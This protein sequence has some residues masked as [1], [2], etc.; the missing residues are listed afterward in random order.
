MSKQ[1]S[2]VI[3]T[4]NNDKIIRKCLDSVKDFNEIVICDMYST[5][6]TIEIAKEYGCKI[7]M[8]ENI[9][10]ADPARNFAISQASNDWVLVVD[11]DEQITPELREY[12]YKFIEDPKDYTALWIPRL[13]YCWGKPMELLY[14]DMIFRLFKK[15]KAYFPPKV[16]GRPQINEGKEFYMPINNRKL[17]IIHQHTQ[18][19]SSIINKINKYTDLECEKLIQED[20]DINFAYAMWRSLWQVLEKFLLKK[21]YKDG[22]RGFYCSYIFGVYK[23]FT[24]V[25]YWEYKNKKDGKCEKE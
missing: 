5:D 17:A 15:G 4:Y 14:P 7:V 2:V 24:Y 20:K 12:L 1:I 9:G 16:H 10:W 19:I 6:K 13:N 25:K 3:H 18:N 8:H 21:G 22:L 23:F 11:S